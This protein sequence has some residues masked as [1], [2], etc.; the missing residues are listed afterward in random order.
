MNDY[1]DLIHGRDIQRKHV[2]ELEAELDVERRRLES[3]C[4]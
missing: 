3:I 2:A 4:R 1:I